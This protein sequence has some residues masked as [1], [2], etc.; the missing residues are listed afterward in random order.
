MIYDVRGFDP[1]A[2]SYIG[3]DME[4]VQSDASNAKLSKYQSHGKAVYPDL[5]MK[6][7]I[8][9][10]L[11]GLSKPS[12]RLMNTISNKGLISSSRNPR[13]FVDDAIAA[14][15]VAIQVDNTAMV[16]KSFEKARP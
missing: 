16:L 6:P 9:D 3:K 2:P 1:L 12:I 11:G 8:F 5:Q 10:T 15:S 7:L 4:K 13:K 14:I